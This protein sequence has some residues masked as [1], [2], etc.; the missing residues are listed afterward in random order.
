MKK[1]NNK[2]FM[3]VETLLVASFISIILVYLFV[4]IRNINTNYSNTIEYNSVNGMYINFQIKQFMEQYNVEKMSLD[5]SYTEKGYFDLKECNKEIF[6]DNQYCLDFFDKLKIKNSIYISEKVPVINNS[7]SNEFTKFLQTVAV[8]DSHMYVIA[9]EF[10]DGSF[11]SIKMNGFQFPTLAEKIKKQNIYSNVNSGPGLYLDNILDTRYV[12]KG[13][14][15][16]S[17][18]NNIEIYGY[19]GKIIA[20]EDQGVKVLLKKNKNLIF[21]QDNSAFSTSNLL[22]KG[23]YLLNS[24]TNSNL[25]VN[26]NRSVIEHE[27]IIKNATFNV[28][29]INTIVGN[30]LNN[31]LNSEAKTVYQ[32]NDTTGYVG[33]INVSDIIKSSINSNCNYNNISSNCLLNNW[34]NDNVWTLNAHTADKVW[35]INNNNFL[36]TSISSNSQAYVVVYLDKMLPTMGEGTKEYPYKIS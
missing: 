19:Q 12:F 28:G 10:N 35:S 26:L 18:N 29:F 21:N 1:M 16:D 36:S 6:I 5:I 22:I 34:L 31:I 13:N 17:I 7:F 20:I 15:P 14:T 4:Q 9:T 33:T 23:A 32:G 24:Q 2:G 8:P 3:L 27:K 30:S 11:A 25:F